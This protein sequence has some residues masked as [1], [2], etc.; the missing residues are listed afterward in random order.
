M[1]STPAA[2]RNL[3]FSV[4]LVFELAMTTHSIVQHVDSSSAFSGCAFIAATVIS[5]PPPSTNMALFSALLLVRVHTSRT[6]AIKVS[7]DYRNRRSM[8]VREY[9][10]YWL[11]AR[12]RRARKSGTYRFVELP[13]VHLQRKVMQSVKLRALKHCLDTFAF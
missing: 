10:P 2:A 4:A 8:L 6:M 1:T 11:G 3:A 5:M 7:G 12:T 13:S 9:T